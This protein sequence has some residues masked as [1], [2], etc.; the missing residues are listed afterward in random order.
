MKTKFKKGDKVRILESAT[1]V[2]VDVE[3]VGK[4]GVITKY[5]S[6]KGIL[7]LMDKPLKRVGRRVDWSVE[8]SMI[9]H[10]IKKGQQLLFDFMEEGE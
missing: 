4:T 1:D 9:E 8:G 7:V 3:E 6:Y 5:E 10:V 2:M